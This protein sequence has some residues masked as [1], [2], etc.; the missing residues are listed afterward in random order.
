MCTYLV[1]IS[2]AS[3]IIHH[4][5]TEVVLSSLLAN[6]TFEL[7]EKPIHWHISAITFPSSSKDSLKPEM[8]LRVVSRDIDLMSKSVLLAK[9]RLAIHLL[10]FLSAPALELNRVAVTT[11]RFRGS[12]T[13]T[14][15]SGV[16]ITETIL[17]GAAMFI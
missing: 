12:M 4:A 13:P 14:A 10:T 9:N 17:G 8:F 2:R 6:F 16:S 15:T 3:H 1:T 11:L 7:S 5:V